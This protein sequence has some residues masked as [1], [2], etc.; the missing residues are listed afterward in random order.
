MR[1]KI[2][3]NI[4][5]RDVFFELTRQVDEKELIR[6]ILDIDAQVGD[7]EFSIQLIKSLIS[8]L[9]LDMKQKE[10]EDR[11]SLRLNEDVKEIN[12]TLIDEIKYLIER[13]E[14]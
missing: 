9:Q 13:H 14:E 3:V 7:V 6:L 10:I 1:N 2:R 8:T 12:G 4:D 11:L 5:V